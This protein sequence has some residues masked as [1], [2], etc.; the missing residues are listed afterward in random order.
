ME[1]GGVKAR[2]KALK[3][4]KYTQQSTRDGVGDG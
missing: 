1:M 2:I 4:V 3:L